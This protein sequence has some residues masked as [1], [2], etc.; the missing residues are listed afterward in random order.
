MCQDLC[1]FED[2]GG[3]NSSL[4][5]IR[6]STSLALS[7]KLALV[8]QT[9]VASAVA[10]SPTTSTVNI[11]QPSTSTSETTNTLIRQVSLATV[12]QKVTSRENMSTSDETSEDVC[13]DKSQLVRK[14]NSLPM[15]VT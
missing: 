13:S 7:R 15:E 6:P 12:P 5:G 3:I 10:L 14:T 9:R 2:I 1:K 11:L 4:T 8:Q